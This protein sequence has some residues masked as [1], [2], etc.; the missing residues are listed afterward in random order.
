MIKGRMREGKNKRER[1]RECGGKEERKEGKLE[2]RKETYILL[3]FY[4]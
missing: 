2:R 3:T 4:S 1:E